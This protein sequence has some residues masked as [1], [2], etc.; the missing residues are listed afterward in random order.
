M[1]SA[2]WLQDCVVSLSPCSDLL[3]L[4]HDQKAAFLSGQIFKQT[5]ISKSAEEFSYFNVN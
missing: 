2:P 3:V 1:Q 5:L 4:A